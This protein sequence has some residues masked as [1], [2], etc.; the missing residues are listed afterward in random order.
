MRV[1]DCH[2]DYKLAANRSIKWPV[3]RDLVGFQDGIFS[4]IT[5]GEP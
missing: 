2:C 1:V 4:S 3:V 5:I